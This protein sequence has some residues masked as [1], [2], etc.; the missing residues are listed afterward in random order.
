MTKEERWRMEGLAFCLRVL[1]QNG[2]DVE[3]LKSE[4]R[5]RGAAGI[6]IGVTPKQEKD[7]CDGVKKAVLDTVLLMSMAV[8]HDTFGFGRD[9]VARFV[10]AFNNASELLGDDCINWTEIQQGIA[11]QLGFV[12]GIRW[13]NGEPYRNPSEKEEGGDQV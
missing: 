4:I 6:P 1:E 3:A 9:R 13:L 7:F 8:L 10:E 11:D 5:R 2:N 12:R